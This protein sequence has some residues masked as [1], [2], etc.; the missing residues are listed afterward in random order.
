MQDDEKTMIPKPCIS[1]CP[2][3]LVKTVSKYVECTT[4]K[5][6]DE[7]LSKR[8]LRIIC[9]NK[10]RDYYD[11]YVISSHLISDFEMVLEK[12]ERKRSLCSAPVFWGVHVAR[13][14]KKKVVPMLGLLDIIGE[15]KIAENYVRVN[16][17]GEKLFLYGRDVFY[18][19]IVESK[20][21]LE[22]KC[23]DNTIIVVNE[24]NVPIG[25]GVVKN[26]KKRAIV[27]NL[28]DLGWYLRSGV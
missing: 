9:N 5:N 18:E 14:S 2:E 15:E 25:W 24:K 13:K 19:N 8:G 11:A 3:D 4:G 6:L 16:S 23:P 28:L 26:I 22:N 20:L 17:L 7:I 12:T 1:Q 27:I 21:R 10:N